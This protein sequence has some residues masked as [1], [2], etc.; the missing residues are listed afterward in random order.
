MTINIWSDVRCPFCYIGKHK[1]EN[2]LKQFPHKDQVRVIWRSFEL[3]PDLQTRTDISTLDYLAEHKMINKAQAEEMT[4]YVAQAA[5]EVGLQFDT[6]KNVV[7][8]TFKAHC[9]IQLAQSK[10]RGDAAE[11]LLFQSHFTKGENVDDEATLLRIA[12]DIGLDLKEVNDALHTDTYARKVRND[13]EE[14]RIMG[15]RGVPFFV[16]NDQYAVSG[17]QPEAV[18]LNALNQSWNAFEKQNQPIVSEG[19]YCS[20]EGSCE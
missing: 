10:N 4:Q 14:A 8:N 7:A 20:A 1:F 13:E 18:F 5:Q 2:A 9:L 3:D 12:S 19:G 17:A 16:F 15:I 6:R 11:E